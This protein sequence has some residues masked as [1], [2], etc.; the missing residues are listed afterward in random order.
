MRVAQTCG[1]LEVSL[2]DAETKVEVEAHGDMVVVVGDIE[3][4]DFLLLALAVLLQVREDEATIG[5]LFSPSVVKF[6]IPR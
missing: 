3:G 5:D 6:L 1:A 4:Y 2:G